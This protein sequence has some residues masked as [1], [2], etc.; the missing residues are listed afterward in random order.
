MLEAIAGLVNA[1]A[2]KWRGTATAL[3]CALGV[4]MKPNTLTMRLNITAG[5]LFNEHGVR[6]QNRHG[7]GP[8]QIFLWY[9]PEDSAV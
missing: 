4:E 1:S 5:R 8:R 6:Y 2:P 7:H 9:A 3:A